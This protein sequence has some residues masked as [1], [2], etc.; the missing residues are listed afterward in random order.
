[1]NQYDIRKFQYRLSADEE[2]KENKMSI[3]LVGCCGAYCGSCQELN[4]GCKGCKLGYA[5]GTRDLKKAKCKIKV[6][7][8]TKG[9]QSCADC[10]TYEVCTI[11]SAFY[12]KNGHKYRKYREA[13]HYIV[14]NGYEAFLKKTEGWQRAYGKLK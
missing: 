1:M 10:K 6:C 11:L 7:C 5:D 4:V 12:Q 2:A 9:H 8:M 13:I 3:E 14:S